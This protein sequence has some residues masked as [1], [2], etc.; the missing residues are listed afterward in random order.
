VKPNHPSSRTLRDEAA[1]V[2]AL[3]LF[4]RRHDRQIGRLTGNR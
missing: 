3:L 4:S 2:I 1:P